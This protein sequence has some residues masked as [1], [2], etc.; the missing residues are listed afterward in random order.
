MKGQQLCPR[1][2]EGPKR[3]V[4]GGGQ[5]QLS[6]DD[7][8]HDEQGGDRGEQGEQSQRRRLGPDGPLH[9]GG[10]GVL[11]GHE[12]WRARFGELPGQ[13]LGVA[14]ESCLRRARLQPH[15]ST[16]VAVVA[17]RLAFVERIELVQ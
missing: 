5:E 3:R 8:A 13:V 14:S 7:L 17:H 16:V 2:A 11:I 12:Q 9:L 15:I 6:G 4:L 10:L 1:H